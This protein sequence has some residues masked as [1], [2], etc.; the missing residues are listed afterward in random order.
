MT[1][2]I[3]AKATWKGISTSEVINE[4]GQFESTWNAW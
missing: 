1:Q 3:Q 2:L 4:I